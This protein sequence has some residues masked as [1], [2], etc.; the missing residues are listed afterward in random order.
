MTSSDEEEETDSLASVREQV[1]DKIG[2]AVEVNLAAS[3][4]RPGK[5]TKMTERSMLIPCR[6]FHIRSVYKQI[7]QNA[8]SP[9][10]ALG[11]NRNEIW[12]P[13]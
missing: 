13:T 1:N 3:C 12:I 11:D 7:N 2:D 5:H 6:H 4:M 9:R 10:L 8:S